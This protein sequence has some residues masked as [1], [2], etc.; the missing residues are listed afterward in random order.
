MP[1][2][3]RSRA[4]LPLS[5]LCALLAGC[6]WLERW[7][8][9]PVADAR[10]FWER[11]RTAA[12]NGEVEKAGWFLEHA[13]RA[14]PEDSSMQLELARFL[15]EQ[16]SS[17]AAAEHLRDAIRQNPDDPN[18]YVELARIEA[19]AGRYTWAERALD[20]ALELHSGHL[21]ALLLKAEIAENQG[22]EQTAL[23]LYHRVLAGDPNNM[24]AAGRAA[25]IQLSA[26]QPERAAPLLR[27]ICQR[28]D[29]TL[30]QRAEAL[31]KLGICYGQQQR[32][33]DAVAAL[34]EALPHRREMTADDWYRLAYARYRSGDLEGA[35][36]DLQMAIRI[37]PNHPDAAAMARTVQRSGS[38]GGIDAGRIE[39]TA[40]LPTPDGW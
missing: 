40:M 34:T 32:W 39:R 17:R 35:S 8:G 14:N 24:V 9:N 16:G 25:E 26:G 7:T 13:V 19:S 29:A 22:D 20:R 27:S 18:V 3:N 12:E 5:V 15:V 37:Q 4:S 28:Q 2:S 31:W 1:Q 23:K 30:E 6:S 11:A 21:E 33:A 38:R 10:R 36:S